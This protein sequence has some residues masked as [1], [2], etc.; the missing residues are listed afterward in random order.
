MRRQSKA[1]NKI[2]KIRS[3]GRKPADMPFQVESIIAFASKQPSAE[4]G[5]DRMVCRVVVGEIFFHGPDERPTPP[6]LEP[7]APVSRRGPKINQ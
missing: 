5:L 3:K 1:G 6:A 2:L 4:H 7:D